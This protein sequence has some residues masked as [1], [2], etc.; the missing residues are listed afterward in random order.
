MKPITEMTAAEAAGVRFVL[1]DID[2]S[3][4]QE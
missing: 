2:D 3:I 4:T 1:M